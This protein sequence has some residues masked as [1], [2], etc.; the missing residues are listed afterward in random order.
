MVRFGFVI[1]CGRDHANTSGVKGMRISNLLIVVAILLLSPQALFSQTNELS[2]DREH[3]LGCIE[4]HFANLSTW[5]QGDFLIRI[6]VLSDGRYVRRNETVQHMKQLD[7]VEGADAISAVVETTQIHRVRFDFERKNLFVANRISGSQQLFD[8]LDREIGEPRHI[9]D[10]RV[11]VFD[12]SK[13]IGAIRN[14]A[15]RVGLLNENQI[16]TMEFALD[17][18]GVPNP[19]LFG[20]Q[21]SSRWGDNSVQRRYDF[22]LNEEELVS[23]T[24]VGRDLYRMFYRHKMNPN[25][26]RT[27]IRSYADWDVKRQVPVKFT[28]Y[29]D[30]R[31][32]G[33]AGESKP[34]SVGT[35]DWI[36]LGNT[37]LPRTVRISQG[38]I[39][40][41]DERQFSFQQETT[42][43]VHW[44]SINEEL[45]E[46]HFEEAVVHD[47]ALLDKLLSDE[48]LDAKER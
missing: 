20:M 35:A 8:S 4:A 12:T 48:I 7:P 40:S 36:S 14:Q 1:W 47:R 24:N 19:A 23:I 10:D 28:F 3:L 15:G 17:R 21:S 11:I 31:A 29:S 25:D 34:I 22:L 18:H 16:P 26:P 38:K 46:E 37:N 41:I 6:R 13:G 33:F 42:I 32:E 2:V 9:A 45:P 27:R 44:F 30:Y 39:G 43:D 5:Q